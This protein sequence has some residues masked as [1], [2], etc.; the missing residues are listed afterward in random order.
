MN[1]Q[2]R[3]YSGEDTFPITELDQENLYERGITYEKS[4]GGL[5]FPPEIQVKE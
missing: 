2:F 1:L 3:N 5:Q 4:T